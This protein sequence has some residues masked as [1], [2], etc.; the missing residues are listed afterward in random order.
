[1]GIQRNLSVSTRSQPPAALSPLSWRRHLSH[2]LSTG[3]VVVL[4]LA[5]LAAWTAPRGDT[6]SA[7]LPLQPEPSTTPTSKSA[8]QQIQTH[9]SGQ[10][11]QTSH[12]SI[13]VNG[14]AVT[15]PA[16]GTTQRVINSP[17]GSRTTVTVSGSQSG[18][19]SSFTQ[20]MINSTTSNVV[21]QNN[22]EE[23]VP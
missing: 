23:V 4:F 6:L 7:A 12:T 11:G 15:V 5:A 21:Q 17:D 8:S 13:T 10:N 22:Q 18:N 16:N 2:N 9:I 20:T 14:Q 1:M 19:G 3:F